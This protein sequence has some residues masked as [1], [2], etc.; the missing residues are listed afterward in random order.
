MGTT[1]MGPATQVTDSRGAEPTVRAALEYLVIYASFE[2][3]TTKVN[4]LAPGGW[5]PT[6]MTVGELPKDQ[7]RREKTGLIILLERPKR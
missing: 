6:L 3:A 1:P 5:R 7:Q 2:E 4:E